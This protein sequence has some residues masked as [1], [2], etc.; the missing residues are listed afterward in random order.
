MFL[1]ILTDADKSFPR[2]WEEELS[3]YKQS[4]R[5]QSL[6]LVAGVCVRLQL[7]SL[8][9]CENDKKTTWQVL[10]LRG[11]Q[12]ICWTE[13][14]PNYLMLVLIAVNLARDLV[15]SQWGDGGKVNKSFKIMKLST[16]TCLPAKMAE[17]IS[18]KYSFPLVKW[19]RFLLYHPKKESF[20][21]NIVIDTKSQGQ[22]RRKTLFPPALTTS[23][24]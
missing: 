6:N 20:S 22:T 11:T 1:D 15:G 8:F 12:E 23:T 5:D 4:Q 9:F 18:L 16:Q 17:H 7:V 14:I 10:E 2:I 19:R 3:E 21:W 24:Q 13:S